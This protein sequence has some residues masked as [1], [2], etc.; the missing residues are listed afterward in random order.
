VPQTS[1][2]DAYLEDNK[3]ATATEIQNRPRVDS[4]NGDMFHAASGDLV[5]SALDQKLL[6]GMNGL[7]SVVPNYSAGEEGQ[8]STDVG[9]INVKGCIGSSEG[10]TIVQQNDLPRTPSSTPPASPNKEKGLRWMQRFNENDDSSIAS[11]AS[12]DSA[13]RDGSQTSDGSHMGSPFHRFMK[14]SPKGKP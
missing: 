2:G 1:F 5:K 8:G 12:Y 10:S 6:D 11:G 4:S 13:A 7:M 3:K 9:S 14:K